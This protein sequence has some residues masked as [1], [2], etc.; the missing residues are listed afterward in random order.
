MKMNNVTKVVYSPNMKTV[1]VY[2]GEAIRVLSTKG[3]RKYADKHNLA[4]KTYK[5]LYKILLDHEMLPKYVEHIS[6]EPE[7]IGLTL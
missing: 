1:V 3:L 6:A 5:D 7:Q 4:L 2:M